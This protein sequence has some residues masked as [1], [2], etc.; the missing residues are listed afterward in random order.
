MWKQRC[1]KTD[2]KKI[3]ILNTD[4]G[5]LLIYTLCVLLMFGCITAIFLWY[6]KGYVYAYDSYTQVYSGIYYFKNW[7][8][9]IWTHFRETGQW[10]IPQWDMKIGFGEPLIS[11][12]LFN[13][14]TF[15]SIFFPIE[16]LEWYFI[17]LNFAR[18]WLS[19]FSFSLYAKRFVQ[20]R[21]SILLASFIYT[22]CG[23]R[24]MLL[25]DNSSVLVIAIALPIMCIG[26]EKILK[27]NKKGCFLLGVSICLIGF[28]YSIIITCIPVVGYACIRYYYV[29]QT[30]S[31]KNFLNKVWQ[32][33]C[34]GIGALLL[35][36]YQ[37]I[38]YACNA[39]Q[40]ART[41]G[42]KTGN[43]LLRDTKYYFQAMRDIL[44]ITKFN[45]A[46]VI[47]VTSIGVIA[48][49]YLIAKDKTRRDK[50]LLIGML[51]GLVILVIPAADL[52]VNLFMGANGRFQYIYVFII[53]MIVAVCCEEYIQGKIRKKISFITL[54]S[55]IYAAI[56]IVSTVILEERIDISLVFLL[57]DVVLLNLYASNKGL[58][59]KGKIVTF[60]LA[61]GEVLMVSVSLFVGTGSGKFQ[62]FADYN[63]EEQRQNTSISMLENVNHENSRVD[64]IYDSIDEKQ[65][66][67]NYG[68]RSDCNG[69]NSYYSYVKS[70]IVDYMQST[71][72]VTGFSTFNILDMNQRTVSDTL[73]GVKYITATK[74][75]K[76]HIP[77][78]YKQVAKKKNEK[79]NQVYY[80]FENKNA[81]PLAYTYDQYITR[82]EY[83]KYLPYEKEQLMLDSVVLDDH[84]QTEIESS[85]VKTDIVVN[86]E[87][88]DIKKNLSKNSDI[89]VCKDRIIVYKDNVECTIQAKGMKNREGY[90]Y[91]EGAKYKKFSGDVKNRGSNTWITATVD[92]RS[93][94]LALYVG[95]YEYYQGAIDRVINLG[96][97]DSDKENVSIQFNKAGIYYFKN[98]QVA[99]ASMKGYTKKVQKLKED[100]IEDF[101]IAGNDVSLNVNVDKNKVLCIAIPYAQGWSAKINGKDVELLNCNLMYMG[102]E[103]EEGN[104]QVELHYEMPGF[105]LGILC[106]VIFGG[107][108][109]VYM[110]VSRLRVIKLVRNKE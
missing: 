31:I 11:I 38:P 66:Q 92:D 5:C 33:M 91:L 2:I 76:S 20:D 78:G 67:R 75:S 93:S 37:F 21:Y 87:F 58:T 101:K 86:V 88:D 50:Q 98:I 29:V 42:G 47:G 102:V 44:S 14:A 79:T 13:P 12:I 8:Y 56:Y 80:L 73:A 82:K 65:R 34:A 64:V 17:F 74:T 22:F 85:N 25:G 39:L 94:E 57:A 72:I 83:D 3:N 108:L 68:L 81:L 10:I 109:L 9:D 28:P 24:M 16:H 105:K 71:G 51:L 40:S 30:K 1:E 27:E 110:I 18:L 15:V 63:L 55:L 107:V 96:V 99:S 97:L 19:G 53:A 62:L 59:N 46:W 60:A 103:L 54:G 95:N 106:S 48:I 6:G 4:K 49:L 36:A 43:L 77:Y 7:I 90:L 23:A 84:V 89:K 61:F 70:G 35:S 26:I 32:A 100:K 69:V 41:G 52:A 45:D 104:N